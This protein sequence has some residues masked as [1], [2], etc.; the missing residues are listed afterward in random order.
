[1]QHFLITYAP[2]LLV[3]LALLLIFWWGARPEGEN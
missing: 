3:V 2:P 1:M